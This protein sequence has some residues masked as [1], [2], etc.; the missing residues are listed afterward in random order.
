MQ[1]KEKWGEWVSFF[2]TA[3]EES[4]NESIATAVELEAILKR[5]EGKVSELRLRSDSVVNR[6][7]K[8]LIGTPVV[9]ARQVEAALGV[10]Y[11]AAN[12]ALAKLEELE[13][14]IN[15]KNQQRHRI[16]VAQEVI[17]LLNR[18]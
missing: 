18:P 7:P 3:V 2:A 16:F 1:L 4:V 5:W 9:S 8:P 10:S 12:N 13:F 17:D 14:L 15:P 11:P 6:L